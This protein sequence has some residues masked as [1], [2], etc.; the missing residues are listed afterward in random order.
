M[1]EVLP[2]PAKLFCCQSLVRFNLAG[3]GKARDTAR[4]RKALVT[5]RAFESA[6]DGLAGLAFRHR[7]L[8]DFTCARGTSQIIE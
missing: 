4:Y 8:F 7:E 5:I 3:F 6:F 2:R 1:I